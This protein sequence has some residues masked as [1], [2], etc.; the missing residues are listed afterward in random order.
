MKLPSDFVPKLDLLTL[1][2]QKYVRQAPLDKQQSVHVYNGQGNY[3]AEQIGEITFLF[4]NEYAW[5]YHKNIEIEFKIGSKDGELKQIGLTDEVDYKII[6]DDIFSQFV[7]LL[8]AEIDDYVIDDISVPEGEILNIGPGVK[9]LFTGGVNFNI[10][11]T[12]KAIGTENDSIIFD[13]YGNERWRGFTLENISD[14]KSILSTKVVFPWS[15]CA[16]IAIF[17][18]FI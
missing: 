10:Y 11:G 9:V 2:V 6:G 3:T 14:A 18:S 7:V 17:L 15:T 12:L 13:N 5:Y 1:L 4:N 8:W 16:I